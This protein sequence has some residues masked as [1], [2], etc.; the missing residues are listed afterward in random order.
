[1]PIITQNLDKLF[2]QRLVGLGFDKIPFRNSVEEGKVGRRILG[3]CC[4]SGS[5]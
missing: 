2:I 4:F 5:M 3:C 1:M